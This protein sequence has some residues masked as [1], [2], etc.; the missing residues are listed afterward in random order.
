M[1]CLHRIPPQVHLHPTTDLNPIVATA[2]DQP[3]ATVTKTGIDAVGLDC[4]P[5]PADTTS[6][7]TVIPTETVQ[8]H[9]TGITNVIMG[10]L[11]DAHVLV[12]IHIIHAVTLHLTD[13]LHT[14]GLQITLEIT[15]DYAPDQPTNQPENSHINLHHILEDHKVKHTPKNSRVTIDDPQMDFYSSDDHSS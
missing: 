1:D 9:I 8:S 13:H 4:S 7:A 15:A 12:I 2:T 10:V 14:E 5:I 11:H 3:H 6:E